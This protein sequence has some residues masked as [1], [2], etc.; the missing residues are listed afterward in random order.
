VKPFPT[1]YNKLGRKQKGI[2]VKVEG[3]YLDKSIINLMREEWVIARTM[4][5]LLWNR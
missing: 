3:V 2:R 1:L 5:S 4:R